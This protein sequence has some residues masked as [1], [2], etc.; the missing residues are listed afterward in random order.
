MQAVH[1]ARAFLP[2]IRM[3]ADSQCA[4]IL[5][6][7][8]CAYY[9]RPFT[10]SKG[11]GRLPPG[12]VPDE[13]M[14]IHEKL[15]LYRNKVAAHSDSDHEHEGVAVNSVFFRSNGNHVI[16]EDRHLCPSAD[17]LVEVERLLD[18]VKSLLSDA[19]GRCLNSGPPSKT[20]YPAG[21]YHLRGKGE[22]EWNFVA[23]QDDGLGG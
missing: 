9:T 15:R 10:R 17:F 8:L 18:V 4:A 6:G 22:Q 14:G 19:V 16:V 2:L 7:A 5:F 13:L 1:S 3:Q 23:V 12:F 20:A 21:L 11:L